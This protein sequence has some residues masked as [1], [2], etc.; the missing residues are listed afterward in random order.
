VT[1]QILLG[2]LVILVGVALVVST[3]RRRPKKAPEPAAAVSTPS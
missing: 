3:E 2:G 1:V